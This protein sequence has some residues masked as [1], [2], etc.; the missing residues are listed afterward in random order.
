MSSEVKYSMYLLGDIKSLNAIFEGTKVCLNQDK[1][2]FNAFEC[3]KPAG[4]MGN[5]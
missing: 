3:A 5:N 4:K 2:E 1:R